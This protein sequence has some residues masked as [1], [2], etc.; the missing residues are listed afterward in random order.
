MRTRLVLVTAC[1]AVAGC[2]GGDDP[3]PQR[4]L[5]PVV[6]EVNEPRD[7][8]VVRTESVRVAGTVSPDGAAVR[9]NGRAAEIEGSEF[10]AEVPLDPGAN[11]IDVIASARGRAPSLTAVRVTRELPVE[12]PDL[13]GLPVEEAE[14]RLAD[15][16]L[17]AE[18]EEDGGF[19]DE[20]LPGDPVVCQQDPKAGS[21]V[22]RGT[23]VL[24]TIGKRC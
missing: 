11:V 9:V 20:L 12:V 4:A 6:L 8:A 14:S 10:T 13:D 16:G 18:V 24:L 3:P 2:G 7:E 15:A 21:E 23:V 1:L 19:F 22:R 17:Q 5:A